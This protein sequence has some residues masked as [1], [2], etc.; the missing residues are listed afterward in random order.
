MKK[1][2]LRE[3]NKQLSLEYD[4]HF[5]YLTMASYF[6]GFGFDGFYQFM[7][8]QSR[9]K[10]ERANSIFSFICNNLGCAKIETKGNYKSSYSSVLDV[11]ECG[12][13]FE[14]SLTNNIDS[15]ISFCRE[16]RYTK[17]QEFMSNF[18]NDQIQEEYFFI[19]VISRLRLIGNDFQSLADFDSKIC[20]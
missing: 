5:L 17:G 8:K 9:Y 10:F 15:I 7:V 19:Q 4:A 2:T 16:N 11:F 20:S 1:E 12:L 3:F 13:D 18:I 14:N 6:K